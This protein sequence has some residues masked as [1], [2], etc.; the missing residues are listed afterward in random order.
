MVRTDRYKLV[1][2]LKNNVV[3]LYDLKKDPHEMNDLAGKAKYRKIADEL[4]G[5][6]LSKQLEVG[7]EVDVKSAYEAYWA[8]KQE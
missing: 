7:D 3:R 2:Y 5:I 4:F 8:N 1:L 6:L